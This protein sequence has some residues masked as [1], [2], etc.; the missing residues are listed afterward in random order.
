V[1]RARGTVRAAQ[2]TV[3]KVREEQAARKARKPRPSHLATTR[4]KR[5]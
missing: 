5:K 3:G 1:T 4:R 2:S